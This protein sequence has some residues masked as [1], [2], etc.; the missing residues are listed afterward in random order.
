MEP[1]PFWEYVCKQRA[2]GSQ[3]Q[4][5]LQ[6]RAFAKAGLDPGAFIVMR[7]PEMRIQYKRMRHGYRLHLDYIRRHGC[8]ATAEPVIYVGEWGDRWN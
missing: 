1:A 5:V 6:A 2:Q 3:K 7:S 8:E 4:F